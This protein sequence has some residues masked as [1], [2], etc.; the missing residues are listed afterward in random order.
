MQIDNRALLPALRSGC[1]D[2]RQRMIVG[3]MGLA[4]LIVNDVLNTYPSAE[5]LRDDLEAEALLSLTEAITRLADPNVTDDDSKPI[6]YIRITLLRDLGEFLAKD[7]TVAV[8]ATTI[9]RH[10]ANGNGCIVPTVESIEVDRTPAVADPTAM[11]ELVEELMACAE[12]DTERAIMEHRIAGRDVDATAEIV[13]LPPHTVYHHI[14]V[15][16]DRYEER[17]RD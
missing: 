14:R 3:N 2:T 16:R 9:R 4:Y 6:G 1:E 8:P 5:R 10:K 12:N 7:R 13:G 11:V 17:C 15:M